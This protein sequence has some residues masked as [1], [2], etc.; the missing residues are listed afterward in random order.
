MVLASL[1]AVVGGGPAGLAAA[2]YTAS[3]G[4]STIVIEE[5][6]PGGQAGTSSK[7]E[8]YPGFPTG[9]SGAA[10]AGRAQAQAQK[11]GVHLAISRAASG[12][13]CDVEPHRV[14]LED[15]RSIPARAVIVATGA[16]YRKLDLPNYARFEGQGIHDAA[17]AMEATLCSNEEVVVVGGGN[18]AGQAAVFLSRTA[19]HVHVLVRGSGLA[20]TMSDYLVQRI[21]TSPRITPHPC[22]E[23]TALDGDG[24]LR[25]V[26]WCNRQTGACEASAAGAGGRGRR[27]IEDRIHASPQRRGRAPAAQIGQAGPGAVDQQLQGITEQIRLRQPRLPRECHELLAHAQL[28]G[29]DELV[30]RVVRVGEFGLGQQQRAAAIFRHLELAGHR[31]DHGAQLVERRGGPRGRLG[32]PGIVAGRILLEDGGHQRILAGVAAVQAHLRRVGGAANLLDP[33]RADALPVEQVLGRALDA[34]GCLRPVG[35]RAG[36]GVS[37]SRD[38]GTM[39]HRKIAS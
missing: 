33:G 39:R 28:M 18:S 6:A 3:E 29:G 35:G 9:I 5:I 4:L 38:D 15:G 26:T 2:V 27:L 22:T 1:L 8:N 21:L 25:E 19:A 36:H 14:L 13:V 24:L 31:L 17:T 11:F 30:R 23:I 10:L 12:L 16:R 34:L 7:I 20:E 32:E 37:P